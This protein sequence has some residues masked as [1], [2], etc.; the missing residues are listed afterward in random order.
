MPL[1]PGGLTTMA[2]LHKYE[3]YEGWLR[4]NIPSFRLPVRE[5][6]MTV[7]G[8]WVLWESKKGVE[9]S[10]GPDSESGGSSGS[11]SPWPNSDSVDGDD[12]SSAVNIIDGSSR[13]LTNSGDHNNSSLVAPGLNRCGEYPKRSIKIRH[14]I[15]NGPL[16]TNVSPSSTHVTLTA[17]VELSDTRLLPVQTDTIYTR[18]ELLPHNR[19]HDQR[20]N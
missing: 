19:R 9:V 15:P 6:R 12:G 4:F 18:R 17:E 3:G 14:K 10:F 1:D 13:N 20:R 2:V 7:G 5:V 11:S 16:N 8:K